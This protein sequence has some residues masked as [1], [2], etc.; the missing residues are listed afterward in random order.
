MIYVIESSEFFLVQ[1]KI[2]EIKKKYQIEEDIHQYDLEEHT[3]D[4]VLEDLD[5]YSFFGTKK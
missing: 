2:E 5:T 1:Q 3:L 4:Q